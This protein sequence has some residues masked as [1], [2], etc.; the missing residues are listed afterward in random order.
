MAPAIASEEPVRNEMTPT[1]RLNHVTASV[2]S[3]SG[4]GPTF[5]TARRIHPDRT[6]RHHTR[7]DA[8]WSLILLGGH[9]GTGLVAAYT[10]LGLSAWA[11]HSGQRPSEIAIAAE[12]EE[13]PQQ[14]SPRLLQGR[15]GEVGA[16][17]SMLYMLIQQ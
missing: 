4:K 3:L 8:P 12:S 17:E 11:V 6:E 16:L 9:Q 13:C 15:Q 10:D 1:N 7:S 2:T 5:R 14:P